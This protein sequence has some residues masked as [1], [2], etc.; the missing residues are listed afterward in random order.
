[1]NVAELK[2]SLG[3]IWAALDPIKPHLDAAAVGSFALTLFGFLPNVV[4]GIT[5]VTTLFWSCIRLY[6]TQTVQSWLSK[7]RFQSEKKDGPR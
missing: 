3:H 2:D 6:E 5:T 1:M 7:H 4:T